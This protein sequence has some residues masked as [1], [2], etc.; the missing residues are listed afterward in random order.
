MWGNMYGEIYIIKNTVNEKVYIGQTLQGSDVRFN[1]HLKLLKSNE[2][3]LIHKAI[4]NYGK[5]KFYYEV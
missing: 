2:N 3:Q 4:K 1:Q 5:V